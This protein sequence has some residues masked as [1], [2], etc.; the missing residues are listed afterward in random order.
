MPE[1]ISIVLPTYNGGSCLSQS[2]NSVLAQ[3]H[4][5]LELIVVDDGS[6]D[7]TAQTI[8]AISD[9][10]LI[11]LQHPVNRGLP[12][13]LNTGFAQASG[14]FLTWTSHDNLYV[15]YALSQLR[16]SLSGGCDF[17]FSDYY[18]FADNDLLSKELVRLPENPQLARNNTIGPCFLYHRR[19]MEAL[20][21][22]DADAELAEDYDYWIR[23]A[24]R[25]KL[26]HVAEPLY[27]YRLSPNSLTTRRYSEVQLVSCLLRL[28]HGLSGIAETEREIRAI[29][30]QPIVKLRQLRQLA[31]S[32]AFYAQFH[33]PLLKIQEGTGSLQAV[34]KMFVD[35]IRRR[36]TLQNLARIASRIKQGS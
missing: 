24:S 7:G 5:D 17:V 2:V 10:R 32:P 29:I 1:K 16:E 18:S 19:V 9:P 35:F 4:A 20:G 27:Y 31:L 14:E 36:W 28:K 23:L 3:T 22:Y 34:R 6:T 26:R 30:M 8:N 15:P 25:F 33:Q 11:F 12:A 21:D 13:A